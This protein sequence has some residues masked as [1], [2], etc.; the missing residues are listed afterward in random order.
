MIYKERAIERETHKSLTTSSR[1]MRP[2]M[3]GGNK[4][5]N[6]R[7]FLIIENKSFDLVCEGKRLDG[8]RI[9]ENGRGLED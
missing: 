5:L 9:S 6:R 2:T 4:M 7:R 1:P 8:M 3:L